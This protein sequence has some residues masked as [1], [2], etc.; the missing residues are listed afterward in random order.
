MLN[1]SDNNGDE[2]LESREAGE[3]S[4]YDN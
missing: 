4:Y 2:L 1:G 3:S